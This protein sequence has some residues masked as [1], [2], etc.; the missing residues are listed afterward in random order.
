MNDILSG[1]LPTGYDEVIDLERIGETNFLYGGLNLLYG[2]EGS[3]KSWQ[4]VIA[5]KDIQDVVYLDCDGSNGKLFVDHCTENNLHYVKQSVVEQV[6]A[7]DMV[8]KVLSLILQ[9][10]NANRKNQVDFRPVFIIDSLTSIGEGQEINNAEKIGPLMYLLNNHSANNNY[11]M[12]LIDHATEL[13]DRGMVLGFKLEGNQGAKKRA[14][15]TTNRYVASNTNEPQNG[16]VFICERA[17]GNAD[18]LT[19]GTE[20][21]LNTANKAIALKWINDKKPEWLNGDVITKTT[22]SRA[23]KNTKDK[24]VRDFIDVIFKTTTEEGKEAY[25]YVKPIVTKPIVKSVPKTTIDQYVNYLTDEH[26]PHEDYI[27]FK[28]EL[29]KETEEVQNKVNLLMKVA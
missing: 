19:K 13:R 21:K 20:H 16:G 17:R 7:K 2:L 8:H 5:L 27:K 12:I 10:L 26:L 18:E 24:W 6:K 9:I 28:D 15:V 14:S 29:S 11:G 22:V 3:G 23:T 4:T 25:K 1:I